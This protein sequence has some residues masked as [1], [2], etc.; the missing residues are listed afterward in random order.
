MQPFYHSSKRHL[1]LR[2]TSTRPVMWREW[3]IQSLQRIR[4]FVRCIYISIKY[5]KCLKDLLLYQ[6]NSF[7][8]TDSVVKISMTVLRYLNK[9]FTRR[10][11][12]VWIKNKQK[13]AGL[14][15][16][17]SKC[18]EYQIQ[19]KNNWSVITLSFLDWALSDFPLSTG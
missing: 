17:F 1:C 13:V 4:T 3:L 5:F 19:S 8:A 14:I 9:R 18:M 11:L 10:K 12:L 6:S 2:K 15:N 16:V 7:Y